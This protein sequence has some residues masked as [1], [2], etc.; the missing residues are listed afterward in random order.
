MGLVFWVASHPPPL[1]EKALERWTMGGVSCTVHQLSFLHERVFHWICRVAYE[2]AA[3]MAI[4][5]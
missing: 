4:Y 5:C 2:Q 3:F 1:W